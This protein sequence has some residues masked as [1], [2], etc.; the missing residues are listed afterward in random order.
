MVR[1]SI[2]KYLESQFVEKAAGTTMKRLIDEN[3]SDAKISLASEPKRNQSPLFLLS[4]NNNLH[5]NDELVEDASSIKSPSF[6][7]LPTF[8]E[9]N[10]ENQSP[11]NFE[12]YQQ[13]HK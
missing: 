4:P 10:H 12:N 9:S 13:K 11:I 6:N 7:K 3:I 5:N 1:E 8:E 2:D